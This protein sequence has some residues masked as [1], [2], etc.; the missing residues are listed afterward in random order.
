MDRTS[1]SP[2][3]EERKFAKALVH[4][5]KSSRDATLETLIT[6]LRN[7][8]DLDEMEMLKLWKA[9]YFCMWL[10]DKKDVQEELADSLAGFIS[11]FKTTQ[12]R[13]LYIGMFFRTILREWTLLDMHRMNKFYYLIRVMTRQAITVAYREFPNKDFLSS[14][15]DILS[16]EVLT[17][18]PNGIRYHL[19]DIIIGEVYN[20]TGGACDTEF[21]LQ[22]LQPFLSFLTGGDDNT[23]LD[24]VS[25]SVFERFISEYSQQSLARNQQQQHT[26]AAV[27]GLVLQ[28]TVFELASA[29][30]TDGRYRARLYALHRSIAAITGHDFVDEALISASHNTSTAATE[31]STKKKKKVAET[32]PT[33]SDTLKTKKR[34]SDVISS[35]T[36]ENKTKKSSK[37]K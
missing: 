23:V 25:N 9:L 18:R 37:K 15:G 3:D 5:D 21:F 16:R 28:H 6:Y 24:R 8:K 14:L 2:I 32:E 10:A 11:L 19:V 1:K 29:P 26:F 27:N 17:K 35:D 4:P 30:E 34:K 13:L 12:L 31:K 33:D 7:L 20:A 22:T 36:S